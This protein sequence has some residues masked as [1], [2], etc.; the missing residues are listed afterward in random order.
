MVKRY[1]RAI[2]TLDEDR[3]KHPRPMGEIAA[4]LGV[5]GSAVTRLLKKLAEAGLIDYRP[6]R[7]VRLTDAGRQIAVRELRRVRLLKAFLMT[8][9]NIDGSEIDADAERLAEVVS[10]QLIAR[11]NDHL[12]HPSYDPHGDPIPQV[13]GSIPA[14]AEISLLSLPEMSAFRIVRV[15]RRDPQFIAWLNEVGLQIGAYGIVTAQ[16]ADGGVTRLRVSGR[17]VELGRSASESLLA[18][19]Q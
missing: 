15:L 17:E 19:L 11:I 12:K 16:L 5:G 14:R 2:M 4:E 8:I 18:A 9:L 3:A 6:N 10:K 1:L 13:D 7:S